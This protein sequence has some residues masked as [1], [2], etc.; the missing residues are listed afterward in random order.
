MPF[1]KFPRLD[2]TWYTKRPCAA[3]I[4][5]VASTAISPS[6]YLFVVHVT[7][8]KEKQSQHTLL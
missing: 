5:I 2:C 1:R 3:D 4:S 7:P 8:R 6:T